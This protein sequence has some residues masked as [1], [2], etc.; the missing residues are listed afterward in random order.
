MGE[1]QKVV[2]LSGTSLRSGEGVQSVV[3]PE[4]V[5]LSKGETVQIINE[6]G[7]NIGL[8]E[9]A[10]VLIDAFAQFGQ[11][12]FAFNA[13]PEMGSWGNAFAALQS[14]VPG[15]S[16]SDKTSVVGLEVLE[17]SHPGITFTVNTLS[18]ETGRTS[19][20]QPNTANTPQPAP[21]PVEPSELPSFDDFDEIVVAK[22]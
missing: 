8:A 9:V 1:L 10:Y 22:Q 6:K 17:L 2:L 19:S 11:N 14:L 20:A 21:E 15:F 7:E 3:L 13:H 12:H 4:V 16:Q 18:A 5:E